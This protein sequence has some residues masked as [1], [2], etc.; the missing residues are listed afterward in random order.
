M[1]TQ[2][3]V[4]ISFVIVGCSYNANFTLFKNYKILNLAACRDLV[5]CG[6]FRAGQKCLDWGEAK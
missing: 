2:S 5:Y 6:Y 3:I 1:Y 4:K